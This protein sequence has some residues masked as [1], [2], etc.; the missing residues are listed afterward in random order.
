MKLASSIFAASALVLMAVPAH[1]ITP[2][3]SAAAKGC[4]PDEGSAGQYSTAGQ[5][6]AHLNNSV[7]LIRLICPLNQ[8]IGEASALTLVV[9]Y[10]DS[11]GTGTSAKVTASVQRISRLTGNGATVAAFTSNSSEATGVVKGS[12][13]FTHT[14]N[15]DT[16]YYFVVLQLDRTVVS[17]IVQVFGVA[18]E[19]AEPS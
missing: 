5:A 11:T 2:L 19:N 17:E 15:F 9:T 16:S 12:A 1:A 8:S 14:F 3:W 18:I 4:V 13:E 10:R 7:A 6:V